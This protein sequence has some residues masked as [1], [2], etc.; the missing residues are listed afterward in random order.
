[1]KCAF[2][3][4]RELPTRRSRSRATHSYARGTRVHVHA[5][6][7]AN[8]VR[9]ISTVLSAE[10]NADLARWMKAIHSAISASGG[11]VD[12][13]KLREQAQAAAS[14]RAQRVQRGSIVAS[15]MQASNTSQLA[16]LDA[17][18]LKE[19]HVKKL[20][21]IAEFLDVVF[22]KRKDKD[23]KKLVDLIVAQRLTHK[24]EAQ[25]YAD[26]D[27]DDGPPPQ[28]KTWGSDVAMNANL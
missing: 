16:K 15:A 24:T 3:K 8:D 11:T 10:T 23:K 6:Q 21:D 9:E 5:W 13:A 28:L 4:Q 27:Y 17:E 18:E 1:M 2:H 22:D 7:G 25:Q 19:L 14:K 20:Q 12:K 26:D